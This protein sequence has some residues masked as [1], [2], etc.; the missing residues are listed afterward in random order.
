LDHETVRRARRR[1]ERRLRDVERYARSLGCR[2]R[3][4]LAHFGEAH[5]PR[6]GRCDVCL[7]RHEAPVVTPSDEPALR[8]IL[9]AVQGGCPREAWF[10]ESEEEA[11]PAPRRDAL[12]TWLVRK[13]Y[14]R[15]D[16][17][18]EERFALTDRG[19]RFL[20]QQG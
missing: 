13:G 5:P 19:E 18:L 8:Q 1:A 11:P 14:L 17:P 2:R 10:A 9:R 12:S 6:C 4:L 16:D 20:G 15:L 3:Y 7:G